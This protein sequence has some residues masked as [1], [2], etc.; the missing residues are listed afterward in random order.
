MRP[1]REHMVE[2]RVPY[3]LEHAGRFYIV[4]NVPARVDLDTGEPY[5]A[6]LTVERLQ[7][8]ILGSREPDR[9]I[10]TPVY[11]YRDRAA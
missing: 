11:Q 3:T 2:R 7:E 10:E 8:T 5:F 1:E 9:V 4:G 6:P